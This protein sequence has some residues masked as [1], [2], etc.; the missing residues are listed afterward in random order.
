MQVIVLSKA[1]TAQDIV[2]FELAA[3]DGNA[4][5]PFSAG[6]H[7]DVHVG[8]MVRQY[9]LCNRPGETH[10]YQIGVLRDANSR[11]GSVAMHALA[12]GDTLEISAPKNHFPLA[13]EARHS[14]LLAGGI[15]VTPLLAMAE[16]LAAEAASFAL[17]YA[18]RSAERTAFRDR[19][20]AAHL[21]PHTRCY[22]D[23]APQDGRLDLAALLSQPDAGAH[24]YVCGP[25][26]FIDAALHQARV[27]GWPEANLHREYFGAAKPA[28]GET[29]GSAFEV[30][31]AHSGKTMTV[32]AGETV[33]DVLRSCGIDWPTSC[34]QGV[35]G[36]CL[37]KVLQGEA[38]HHDNY[39]TEEERAGGC[40]LPCVSRASGLLV[41]D[42]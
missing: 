41:L 12:V 14:I 22:V 36:T 34:E 5:P 39:L 30:R 6:A 18:T 32:R 15:G 17:H 13:A 23:D 33:V 25:A 29:D 27:Q 2:T 3:P 8:D 4:L 10:R 31:L 24:V 42:I 28:A 38:Q 35:C 37:T 7:I 16:Q 21:A 26:G 40:F 20:A 9:S 19:L 11:G 1:D